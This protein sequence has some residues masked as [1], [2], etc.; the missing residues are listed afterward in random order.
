MQD[1]S[2]NIL[3]NSFNFLTAKSMV[4]EAVQA[5]EIYNGILV[6]YTFYSPPLKSI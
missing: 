4:V 2:L 5:Y 6:Y 1:V 3:R